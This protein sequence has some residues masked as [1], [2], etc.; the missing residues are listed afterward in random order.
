MM[1][2]IINMGPPGAVDREFVYIVLFGLFFPVF[3]SF[4]FSF[5]FLL[6]FFLFFPLRILSSYYSSS[7]SFFF[8]FF[9]SFFLRLFA[10]FW[11]LV[12]FVFLLRETV[13]AANK[14]KKNKF[15]SEKTS[16]LDT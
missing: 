5:F 15:Q 12:F 8:F 1:M 3:F 16:I 9:F 14:T 10:N 6:V 13:R 2:I 11:C 4:F 7:S